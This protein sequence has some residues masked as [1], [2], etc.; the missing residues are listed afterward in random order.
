MLSPRCCTPLEDKAAGRDAEAEG[1]YGDLLSR[2]LARA[3][4]PVLLARDCGIEPDDWQAALLRER[5]RRCLM[6]CSRQ[7]GKTEV[8]I[9]LAHLDRTV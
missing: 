2:D 7:S 9:N 3:F 4:D 1:R 6:L 8:A 5:P